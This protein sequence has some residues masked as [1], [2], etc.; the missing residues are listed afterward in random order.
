MTHA[1]PYSARTR[2]HRLYVV[3]LSKTPSRLKT[4]S[5]RQATS[6]CASVTGL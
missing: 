4:A 2:V 3:A 5:A 1:M 6:S